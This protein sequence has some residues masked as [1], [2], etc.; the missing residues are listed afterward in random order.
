MNVMPDYNKTKTDDNKK[1]KGAH[2]TSKC[3]YN[4]TI[5]TGNLMERVKLIPMQR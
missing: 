5:S 4:L 3:F 1:E 2:R